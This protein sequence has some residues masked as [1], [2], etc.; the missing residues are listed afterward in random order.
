MPI[1]SPAPAGPEAH[2]PGSAMQIDGDDAGAIGALD[3]EPPKSWVYITGEAIDKM[4]G[5]V[6]SLSGLP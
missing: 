6:C 1:Q 2:L 4:V 5:R 3:D